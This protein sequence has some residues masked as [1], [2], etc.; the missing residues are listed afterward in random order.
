MSSQ[1]DIAKEAEPVELESSD[2]P[3]GGEAEAGAEAEHQAEAEQPSPEQTDSAIPSP[4]PETEAAEAAEQPPPTVGESSASGM[5]SA[6]GMVVTSS[7]PQET[8][9]FERAAYR[10]P[11]LRTGAI[12]NGA[13]GMQPPGA[14][15]S[16]FDRYASESQ[17]SRRFG[18]N[19]NSETLTSRLR[20]TGKKLTCYLNTECNRGRA[21]IIHLPEACDTLGEVFPLV[22]RRMG[23]DNRMLYAAELFLPDGNKITSYKV[24][25]EAA[26]LDTAVIVGCG[27]P[28][29]SS[30]VP[31][32]ML[33]FHKY[34]GGRE[35][36]KAVKKELAEKKMRAAQLKAD[37]VRASGHGL[38]NAAASA[39][40]LASI[41][42]NRES[43]A[44]MRHDYMNQLIV[45]SSQQ[46]ELIRHVQ[47][48]NA[49]LRSDRAKREAAKLS[50]WSQ[51]RL[52]DLS[53]AHRSEANMWREKHM[54]EQEIMSKRVEATKRVRMQNQS[55]GKLAKTALSEQRKAA[56]L[57]RRMSYISRSVEKAAQEQDLVRNHQANKIER[58]ATSSR[59]G[60]RSPQSSRANSPLPSRTVPF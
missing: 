6:A 54:H 8:V 28:F 45:R 23:L 4:Q 11:P 16:L 15:D 39:A 38:S 5:A 58:R 10:S 57:E 42:T 51:D 46:T 37:Q 47:A 25:A 35:A 27:E 36:P 12:V 31:Q 40:K 19:G 13:P 24:L 53:E 49:R 48:N 7:T 59:L 60:L 26:A 43:A 30:T 32:S 44:M 33:S 22:Q 52:Q 21:T 9:L 20:S 3:V 41:E 55:E 29:D 17:S 2:V 50:V 1:S 18:G 56:G 14:G 34:G